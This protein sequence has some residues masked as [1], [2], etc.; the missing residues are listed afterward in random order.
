MN[1]L[2]F[3][4]FHENWISVK[5]TYRSELKSNDNVDVQQRE[6]RIYL[7]NVTPVIL[8][9]QFNGHHLLPVIVATNINRYESL[10]IVDFG[11]GTGK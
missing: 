2:V 5:S 11:E 9:S 8:E 1:K 7:N 6:L 10:K 3:S 4:G